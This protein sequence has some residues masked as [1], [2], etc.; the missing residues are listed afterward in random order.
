MVLTARLNR[1]SMILSGMSNWQ[2]LREMLFVQSLTV[3]IVLILFL[4][5]ERLQKMAH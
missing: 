2:A 1:T 5:I 4:C 3:T